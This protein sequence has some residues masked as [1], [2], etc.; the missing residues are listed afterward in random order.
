MHIALPRPATPQLSAE[1]E[2]E[3]RQAAALLENN[4]LV[5]R[6]SGLL[7][8]AMGGAAAPGLLMLPASLRDS[9]RGALEVALSRVFDVAAKSVEARTPSATLNRALRARWLNAA[10]AIASGAG[11]G[12][13]GLPGVVAELP[14]TTTLLM[15]AIAQ[16]AARQGEDL[17]SETAKIECLEVF[18]LGSPSHPADDDADLGYYAMRLGFARALGGV[19]GRTLGQ[20]LPGAVTVAATR[21]GVPLAYKVAAEAVPLIGAATG[22]AVNA[23]FV[24]H[25]DAKARGHFTVRRLER[26]YG[27]DTVRAAFETLARA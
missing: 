9:L 20:V 2:A 25:F 3:L 17:T 5:V 18:A 27:E 16:E 19:G 7:G 6:I 26:L 11:G 22:A 8:R 10:A 13:A 21:F 24:S 14:V 1:H 23:L 4:N 15:R 12:M